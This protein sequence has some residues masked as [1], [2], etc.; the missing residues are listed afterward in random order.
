MYV[1]DKHFGMTNVK[2]N[3]L[4]QYMYR[5]TFIIFIITNKCTIISIVHLL[6]IM[7]LIKDAWYMYWNNRVSTSKNL[8]LQKHQAKENER[9]YLV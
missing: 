1:L 5:A 3:Y 4:F 6:V 8:E 2:K 7:K 9:S